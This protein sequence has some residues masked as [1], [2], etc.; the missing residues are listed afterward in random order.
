[1]WCSQKSG[2][3]AETSSDDM[4]PPPPVRSWISLCRSSML[5]NSP[6]LVLVSHRL[7]L[8]AS[9]LVYDN[10][11]RPTLLRSDASSFDRMGPMRASCD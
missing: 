5:P 10:S 1:M 4:W 9:Y 6:G 3:N 8:N 2:S 7:K 11:S